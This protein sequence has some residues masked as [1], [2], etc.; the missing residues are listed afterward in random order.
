MSAVFLL[1][2]VTVLQVSALPDAPQRDAR[3]TS[4]TGTGVIAGRVLA[5]D[6]GL[7]LRRAVV[8]LGGGPQQKTVQTDVDGRYAVTKLPPGTYTVMANAGPHRADYLSRAYGASV[9]DGVFGPRS[10]SRPIQLEAGRVL[11]NI[12]IR[13]PRAAAISGQ[14]V[15]GFGEP[16]SRVY[17]RALRI[18][19]GRPI[20]ESGGAGTDDVG[21]YRLFGLPPGDYVVS[22]AG[23]WG[24]NGVNDGEVLGFDLTYAPGTGSLAQATR[25]RLVA[26]AVAN[27][28]LQLVET[29][30]FRITG[31]VLTSSGDP[32]R[33]AS[34]SAVRADI[35]HNPPGFGAS[36][37]PSGVFTIRNVAPGT[38]DLHVRYSPEPEK[39]M[40]YE[41]AML[42]VEVTGDLEGVVLATHP[43][44][45]ERHFLSRHC[46]GKRPGGW[47]EPLA[48]SRA[49]RRT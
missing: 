16:V 25:L 42:R 21:R 12:D 20:S 47:Y 4:P 6:S 35:E 32:P 18:Q 1:G 23:H 22:A 10:R 15:D 9:P 14:V 45:D 49:S 41:Q 29:R 5:A 24:D 3:P 43:V 33:H 37:S 2:L 48:Q 17:V 28:D 8:Y 31:V 13:L 44:H 34:V 30:L 19:R 46:S 39:P 7:P 36:V 27:A 40:S 11:D 26:G 38:Y